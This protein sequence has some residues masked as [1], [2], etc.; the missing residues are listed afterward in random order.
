MPVPSFKVSQ[1]GVEIEIETQEI[2]KGV[3]HG[4]RYNAPDVLKLS[5]SDIVN[6]L[7]EQK[8]LDDILRPTVRRVT[9]GIHKAAFEQ[10]KEGSDIPRYVEAYDKMFKEFSPV[11]ES[12]SVLR[13][14]LDDLLEQVSE[15]S[16]KFAF[17]D[18]VPFP[19]MEDKE[20]Q[21]FMKLSVQAKGIRE[22]IAQRENEKEEKKAAK[23]ET[24]TVAEPAQA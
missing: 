9:L 10:S 2:K 5:F 18:G 6:F 3:N 13:S 1:N 20:T 4:T 14:Q 11:G 23:V 21:K 8:V 17:K 19:D 22:I 16:P 7:G 12:I 15:L 24:A